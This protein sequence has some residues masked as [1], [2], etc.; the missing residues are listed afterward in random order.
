MCIILLGI[1][2]YASIQLEALA[3]E[4]K[5]AYESLK[6]KFAEKGIDL[7]GFVGKKEP[8]EKDDKGEKHE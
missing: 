5:E 6:E 4:D 8:K 7:D 1:G 2:A 3:E